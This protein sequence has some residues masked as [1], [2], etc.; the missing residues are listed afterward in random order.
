MASAYDALSGEM[1]KFWPKIGG[2]ELGK[3]R[4]CVL[5]VCG[6]KESSGPILVVVAGESSLIRED[7]TLRMEVS[8]GRQIST[9]DWRGVKSPGFCNQISGMEKKARAFVIRF[10][11]WEKK[12]EL[13]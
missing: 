2:R 12:P 3:S 6:K 13:L 1:N 8:R 11:E 5:Y 4:L 7:L 10:R 9:T